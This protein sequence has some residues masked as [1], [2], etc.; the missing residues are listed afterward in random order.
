MADDN[1]R[2][3]D[4]VGEEA[5]AFGERLK[6]AAKDAAGSVTGNRRLEREGEIENAEGRARQARNDVFEETDGV[7]GRSVTD[8]TGSSMRGYS[9]GS[10]TIREE[11]SATGERAKGG[12]KD[13]AGSVLG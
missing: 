11:V 3:D 9:A 7:P 4:S 8:T 5:S 13:A 6:G 12:V 2:R 1:T 10:G